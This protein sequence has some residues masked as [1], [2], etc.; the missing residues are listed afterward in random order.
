MRYKIHP[1]FIRVF[2]IV[3]AI[4]MC[5]SY[6]QSQNANRNTD[7]LFKNSKQSVRLSE[8]STNRLRKIESREVVKNVEIVGVASQLQRIEELR[9]FVNPAGKLV[10]TPSKSKRMY[11]AIRD[12]QFVAMDKY[13]A[14]YGSIQPPENAKNPMT[15]TIRLTNN[16]NGTTYGSIILGNTEYGIKPLEGKQHALISYDQNE[17]DKKVIDSRNRSDLKPKEHKTNTYDSRSKTYS[18]DS[19]SNTTAINCTPKLDIA[20]FYNP[21]AASGRDESLIIAQAESNLKTAFNRS[22]IEATVDIVYNGELNV[23]LPLNGPS[24]DMLD[25]WENGNAKS[26][27]ESRNADIG[28]LLF[29]DPN[30]IWGTVVGSSYGE[31]WWPV[32]VHIDYAVD[33]HQVF[34]HEVGNCLDGQHHPDDGG[35]IMMHRNGREAIDLLNG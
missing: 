8:K 26:I 31:E 11:R 7:L 3:A 16:F 20:V 9:F 28:V 4:A 15:G 25:F 13:M 22:G 5:T 29:E 32:M 34:A 33:N 2:S 17:L 27:I 30:N 35:L 1:I 18:N 23:D 19:Q 14:W 24:D 21:E 10:L 6:A 12:T